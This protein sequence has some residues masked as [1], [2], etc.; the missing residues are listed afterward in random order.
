MGVFLP[1]FDDFA[2]DGLVE[3]AFE[4]EA[5]FGVHA[6]GDLVFGVDE[7][8]DGGYFGGVQA[9]EREVDEVGSVSVVSFVG[10]D[11]EAVDAGDVGGQVFN[12]DVADHACVFFKFVGFDGFVEHAFAIVVGVG[13]EV[14]EF[15][16]DPCGERLE[17]GF[18]DGRDSES[19]FGRFSGVFVGIR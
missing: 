11:A 16:G 13:F 5:V 17:V 14:G 15:G 6:F 1:F 3:H 8:E 12:F 2:A 7:E 18:F 10:F 19:G 9:L 4:R